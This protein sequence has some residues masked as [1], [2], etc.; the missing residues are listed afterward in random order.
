[1]NF[2]KFIAER[3]TYGGAYSFTR[4]ASR[5]A[6]AT[7]ILGV[8]IM[9]I[10]LSILSGYKLAIRDKVT[11]LGGHLII[12]K[13]NT[14]KAYQDTPINFKSKEAED[15]SSMKA[16]DYLQAF[17]FK[18]NLIKAD[19]I[20]QGAVIKGVSEDF[21][22]EM[23]RSNMLE[24]Q[25]LD[26]ADSNYHEGLVMSKKMARL[27]KVEVGDTI[28]SCFLQ[29]PPRFR[30]LY[31]RG[32]Y[33][34]GL[35][36]FDETL[37]LGDLRL[38]Q[39]LNNW[40]DSLA[41]GMEVYLNDFNKLDK[42]APE[43]YEAIP[44]SWGMDKITDRY[45]QL[46]EWLKMLNST[47][48]IPIAIVLV[49]ALFN[50]LS[51]LLIMIL[52]RTNMIGMLKAMGATNRQISGIFFIKGVFIIL[53][54]MVFGNILALALIGIQYYTHAFP[55]DPANYY[56]SYVPVEWVWV[57][58]LKINLLTLVLTTVIFIV[59]VL[60]I[61]NLQPIKAIRFQ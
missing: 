26:L 54:G 48:A 50:M 55:M 7:I 61:S 23:F 25:W 42:L 22:V 32:I 47:A 33:Q 51:T 31:I 58:F 29:N 24:G 21:N 12:T 11:S 57:D 39:M 27:L 43:I 19:D 18:P 46:F 17:A 53:R 38:I 1:M 28:I 14:R 13:F 35:E 8:C 60:L 16:V 30:K 2:S 37:V 20:I 59:P 9:I 41:G 40:N 3:L 6:M 56:V 34:T 5:I 36:E 49:V 15:L 45:I 44:R 4:I 52:E 10:T